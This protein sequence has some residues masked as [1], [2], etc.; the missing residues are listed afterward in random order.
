[1]EVFGSI[2]KILFAFMIIVAATVEARPPSERVQ[3]VLLPYL[4][5]LDHPIKPSLDRLFSSGRPTFNLRTMEE[6]GFAKARP[7]KFTKLIVTSH[8][9][10]P[11]YIFK[12]Y[13]DVQRYHKDQP[14][15]K[16]WI[17]RA[18]GAKIVHSRISAL[19]LEHLFKVPKKW[20]YELPDS[21]VVILKGY[22]PKNFILVEE[23]MYI[24]PKNQN[25]KLWAS[26]T[27]TPQ[28][29]DNVFAILNDAGLYDC[30]K[31]DNIPFSIDGRIAFVDTET[32]GKEK[33]MY[34]KLIPYL[35]ESN[36]EYWRMII[37]TF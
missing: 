20:L 22:Y 31:P 8:P 4:L 25:R 17:M 18:K 12:L 21:S 37:S 29:L 24:L 9:D 7:R 36:R 5:P 6:A 30:A 28:L 34:N 14:E 16:G 11:G 10:F 15:Y 26:E 13:L 27:V 32:V 2:F 19:G 3:K 23:D 33:V 1:M 35:S